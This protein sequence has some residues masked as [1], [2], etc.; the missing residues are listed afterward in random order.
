VNALEG[1][2]QITFRKEP[3]GGEPSIVCPIQDRQMFVIAVHVGTT[4]ILNR[5][6]SENSA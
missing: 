6:T 3:G 5:T 2:L 1:Y 4:I